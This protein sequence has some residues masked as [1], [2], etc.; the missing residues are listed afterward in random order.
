[1]HHKTSHTTEKVRAKHLKQTVI[2]MLVYYSTNYSQLGTSKFRKKD[3]VNRF[4][5]CG[6]Q[7]LNLSLDLTQILTM[8]FKS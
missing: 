5:T 3:N 6:P 7:T 8:Q 4:C 1:M 2:R